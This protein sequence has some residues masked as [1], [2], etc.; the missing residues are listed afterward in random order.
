VGRRDNAVPAALRPVRETPVTAEELARLF[1]DTYERLAPEFGY[2]TREDSAVPWEDVPAA[3]KA[4]MVATCEHVLA[5]LTV[6]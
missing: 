2:R 5:E 6:P 1:H 3:N 4:L